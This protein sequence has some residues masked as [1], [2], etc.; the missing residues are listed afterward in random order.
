MKAAAI[1]VMIALLAACSRE[2]P[3]PAPAAP[4]KPSLA[5]A[6]YAPDSGSIAI[7]CGRLIDG[8]AA[9][10]AG[11]STVVI[12]DGRIESVTA[13]LSAP[14]G[15]PLLDLHEY[16]CLPGLIDMHTHVTENS[17]DTTDMKIYLR[18]TPQEQA[19]L[20]SKQAGETLSAGFTAIRNVGNY[21]AWT[22][23]TLRD[24]INAGR[25]AGPRMQVAGYYLTIPNGGGDLIIP[26]MKPE[27]IP[28]KY[29]AGVAGTPK[30]FRTKAQD[31]IDGGADVLK[32]IA[33]GAVLAYGGV[34]GSP[35]V[36][37][38]SLEAIAEVAHAANRKLAAHAHGAV[39]IKQ[40]IRA[41]ADTIE[42]AS[43]I[44]DEG[45]R[46][47]R[48]KKVALAM[49]VYN[50]D[51]IDTEGRK[52]KWPDEFLRK[53]LETTEA[54]RQ[55]FTKAHAAGVPIVFA[56]D[57]GVFPHGLNARQFPIMVQ[58]GMTPMEAIQSATSVAAHYLGWD[59]R[60]GALASGRF[61]DLIAVKEDPLQDMAHLQ[62]VAAVVKGGLVF[63]LPEQGK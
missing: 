47:A 36:D 2:S 44:D 62:H 22:D 35:E 63:K 43:L 11:N 57:A 31:A 15:L 58:R 14:Q 25:V 40:A 12:R 32:V 13:G 38:P 3:A 52:Q 51:Y 33:S 20:S 30:E 60:V 16:T 8:L 46:M 26:G 39:S 29:H 49:D 5:S 48:D 27:A 55:A 23:R 42:H 19:A 50:G 54:Q 10:P 59:D 9:E 41:G 17:E 45:I 56:T 1:G 6:P 37:E 21:E 18:R 61:G 53:N 28:A 4:A 34:P 24:E 7:Q